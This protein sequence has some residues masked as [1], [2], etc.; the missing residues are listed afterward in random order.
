MIILNVMC[1]NKKGIIFFLLKIKGGLNFDENL[2]EL[3]LILKI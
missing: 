3:R 2:I 1:P